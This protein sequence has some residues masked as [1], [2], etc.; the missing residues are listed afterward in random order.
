MVLYITACPQ[1]RRRIT[2]AIWL[3]GSCRCIYCGV[4]M[5]QS[6]QHISNLQQREHLLPA[7]DYPIRQGVR[8]QHQRRRT[9]PPV[10]RLGSDPPAVGGMTS[11]GIHRCVTGILA[12]IATS[13]GKAYVSNLCLQ[14]VSRKGALPDTPINIGDCRHLK[15]LH[16]KVIS[17][18]QGIR[19]LVWH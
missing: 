4:D 9:T 18:S 13:Q 19:P 3:R 11:P 14:Y 7:C 10:A 8:H 17:G 5:L 1:Y 6:R 15:L 16:R 2:L 12:R